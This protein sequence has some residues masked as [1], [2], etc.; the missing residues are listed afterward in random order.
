MSNWKKLA[1]RSRRR[2][3]RSSERGQGMTP[4]RSY[5]YRSDADCP[6]YSESNYICISND[7]SFYIFLKN[8]G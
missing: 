3:Q 1:A 2:A 8:V 4:R 6:N 7:C 5:S